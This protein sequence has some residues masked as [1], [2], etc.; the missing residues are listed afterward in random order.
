[1]GRHSSQ[2]VPGEKTVA[3]HTDTDRS[4]KENSALLVNVSD[5]TFLVQNEDRKVEWVVFRV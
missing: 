4:A 2:K 5:V 1:M 3:P